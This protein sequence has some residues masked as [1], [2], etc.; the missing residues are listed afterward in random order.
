MGYARH[1]VIERKNGIRRIIL[2][3]T[4]RTENGAEK[5]EYEHKIESRL[6]YSAA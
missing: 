3:C 6:P 2:P 4:V 1:N 5:A